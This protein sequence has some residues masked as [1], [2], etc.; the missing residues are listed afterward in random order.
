[1][2]KKLLCACALFV[3]SY[4]FAG[5]A[6]FFVDEGFS[7]DGS[8]YI[9]S[10]YGQTDKNFRGWAEIFTVDVQKNIFVPN[11]LYAIK[12]AASTAGKTGKDVYKNLR[13]SVENKISKYKCAPVS[14]KEILFINGDDGKASSD[15]IIFKDFG[16]NIDSQ[17]KYSVQLIQSVNGK[18]KNLSSS[19]FIM[20]EKTDKAGNV[21]GRQK[22]GTPDLNRKRVRDYKIQKIFCDKSGQNIVFVVE[23]T[24]ED[25][26][27]VLIRYMVETARLDK[28]MQVVIK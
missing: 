22:I 8:V 27:G 16:A 9:F 21:L 24:V 12:P 11:E 17:G 7:D 18:G 23:K 13:A 10:Q 6:A 25:D 19:F 5:D 15:E 1:M 4:C 3:A 14:A 26:A 28:D 2:K 20:L